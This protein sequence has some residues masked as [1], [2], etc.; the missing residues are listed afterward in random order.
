MYPAPSRRVF[1]DMILNIETSMNKAISKAL[2]SR[3]VEPKYRVFRKNSLDYKACRKLPELWRESQLPSYRQ[4]KSTIGNGVYLA[5][6]NVAKWDA[7]LC[8]AI[9]SKVQSNSKF[10]DLK[11]MKILDVYTFVSSS[12]GWT[13]F[14]AHI[15]FEHSFIF[16]VSGGPREIYIWDAGKEFGA[17]IENGRSF[18]GLSFNFDKYI[19]N[20]RKVSISKGESIIIK[21]FEGHVFHAKSA[22]SFLGISCEDASETDLFCDALV[23]SYD[24]QIMQYI[25]LRGDYFIEWNKFADLNGSKLIVKKDNFQLSDKVKDTVQTL[26]SGSGNT[27]N[28]FYSQ[29]LCDTFY[30]QKVLERCIKFGA[31][32]LHA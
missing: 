4:L 26:K 11:N 10:S 25:G 16:G 23:P 7:E 17:L 1:E 32:R 24:N 2:L 30:A 27:V 5:L 31:A 28:Q 19:N 14:G 8:E 15:D 13:P 18:S 3:E 6:N 20:A 22:G 9:S 12:G 29:C 21:K